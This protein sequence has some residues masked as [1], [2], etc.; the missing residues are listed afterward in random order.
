MHSLKD[1]IH[2]A[3]VKAVVS[4][5]SFLRQI[6][7]SLE[8]AGNQ[9]NDQDEEQRIFQLEMNHDHRN[10]IMRNKLSLVFALKCRRRPTNCVFLVFDIMLILQDHIYIASLPMYSMHS[11]T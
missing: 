2:I 10:L 8:L 3:A 11:F 6:I 7:R 1:K 4:Q 5:R 9:R